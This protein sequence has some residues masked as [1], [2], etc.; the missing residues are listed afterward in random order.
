MKA[1][2][3]ALCHD[4]RAAISKAMHTLALVFL[5]G[6]L[7]GCS[8][9]SITNSSPKIDYFVLQDLALPAPSTTPAPARSSRVLLIASSTSQALFDSERMVFTKDGISRSY[10][11]FANWSERPPQSLATLAETRLSR[12][13]SF[14]AVTQSTAGVKADLLLTL[15]LNE[16][17]HDDS[18]SPGVMRLEVTADLVDWR[19]RELVARRVFVG[20]VA[21]AS[22]D[23]IGG[24]Q[25]ANRAITTM[26]D[27]LSPWVE[28]NAA[29]LK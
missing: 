4:K 10:Y 11:Q 12:V 17:T 28:S 9:L 14:R 22:R 19:T 25:A 15:R 8:S 7:A 23:S 5:G 20:A 6:L 16:L 2:A 3:L 27:D 18:V 21:V 29:R 13:G 24:A 1:F 26:L